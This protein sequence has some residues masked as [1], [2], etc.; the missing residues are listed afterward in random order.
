MI[1]VSLHYHT[2]KLTIVVNDNGKGFDILKAQSAN[3][4]LGL[5]NINNR[6]KMVNGFINF[7]SQ[8][9]KGTTVLIELPRKT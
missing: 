3:N 9:Q 6:I 5:L 2:E 8:P 4:S 7:D 1:F